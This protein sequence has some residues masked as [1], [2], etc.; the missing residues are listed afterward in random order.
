M[1]EFF[2]TVSIKVSLS[3]VVYLEKETGIHVSYCPALDLCSQGKNKTEARKMLT[4]AVEIF[5]QSCIEDDTLKSV[6]QD[7]GFH[8]ATGAVK[9]S[10]I[11]VKLPFDV[12]NP[13]LVNIPAEIPLMIHG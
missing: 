4:E 11:K 12:V 7:C 5:I 8:R 13:Q 2:N 1:G 10:R 6:L 9:K 3:A